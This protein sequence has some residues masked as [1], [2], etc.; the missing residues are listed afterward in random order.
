MSRI[1]ITR[2]MLTLSLLAALWPLSGRGDSADEIRARNLKLV[3][4]LRAALPASVLNDPNVLLLP[5]LVANR[6]RKTVR[7]YAES[8]GIG[9]AEPVEF[10]I[11]AHN[12][13]HDYEAL[14]VS[15]AMPSDIH[16]AM[17]FV[18]LPAGTPVDPKNLRMWPR[19]ERVLIDFSWPVPATKLKKPKQ[20]PVEHFIMDG[21]TQKPMKQEGFLFVGSRMSPSLTDSNE[22]VYAADKI[23]PNSIAA[24]YNEPTTVFDLT[25]RGSKSEQYNHLSSNPEYSIARGSLIEVL[26]RPKYTDGRDHIEDLRLTVT[27]AEPG[28]VRYSL[29]G[30]SKR[31]LLT[32]GSLPALLATFEELAVADKDLY[33]TL[34]IGPAVALAQTRKV[35]AA[36]TAIEGPDGIRMEPPPDGQLYYQAFV[37]NPEFRERAKRFTQPWELHIAHDGKNISGRLVRIEERRDEEPQWQE[38]SYP[39]RT[40]AELAKTLIR[41]S[42]EQRAAGAFIPPAMVVYVPGDVTHAAFMDLI[43]EARKTHPLIHVFVP[44]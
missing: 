37:P 1:A 34:T 7:F 13:G 17:E 31:T 8:T 44:D 15:F 27:A 5:G 40:A 9:E 36:L 21:R 18:G 4:E 25:R 33:V 3:T 29:K 23:A 42:A 12:S 24:N 43:A 6:T 30:A 26:I 2:H 41:V 11:I 20:I 38:T 14:A 19:G 28:G 16:R 10:F 22:M 39:A 35:C 32:D